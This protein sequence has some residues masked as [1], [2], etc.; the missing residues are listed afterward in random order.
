[1]VP[2][3]HFGGG[4]TVP[5]SGEARAAGAVLR[6]GKV[7]PRWLETNKIRPHQRQGGMAGPPARA[8]KPLQV[9]ASFL[10]EQADLVWHGNWNRSL[11]MTII[12]V[13]RRLRLHVCQD[14]KCR[15]K[16]GDGNSDVCGAP[17]QIP[18]QA[19][20]HGTHRV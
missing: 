19:T 2:P 3:H 1:M 6:G 18:S 5:A 4:L 8:A 14:S 15:V 9:L 12:G 10:R 20:D 16:G 13:L 17:R 7:R 11:C